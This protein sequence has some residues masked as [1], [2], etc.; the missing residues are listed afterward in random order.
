MKAK[1]VGDCFNVAYEILVCGNPSFQFNGTPYVVHALVSGTG[2]LKGIRHPHAFV[3]DDYSVYDYANGKAI[4]IG[5]GRYYQLGEIRWM[6]EKQYRK[7]TREE[8]M[9][10]V[11]ETGKYFFG[12][13]STG[14]KINSNMDFNIAICYPTDKGLD[15][16]VRDKQFS[17]N[18]LQQFIAY[19]VHLRKRDGS[20][21]AFKL[22]GR[23]I[24]KNGENWEIGTL[25]AS[26]LKR[27][28]KPLADVVDKEQVVQPKKGGARKAVNWTYTFTNPIVEGNYVKYIGDKGK[29]IN[30]VNL[31]LNRTYSVTDTVGNNVIVLDDNGRPVNGHGL[32]YSRF[33]KI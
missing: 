17:S 21:R 14:E 4:K 11:G 5:K 31:T 2:K 23:L 9:K 22:Q 28:L 7:Y 32:H 8:M 1:A 33:K 6:D 3:E 15:H 25:D 30:D 18:D 10:Y 12:H 24:L 20:F 16:I 26:N 19:N 27:S 13:I 29:P